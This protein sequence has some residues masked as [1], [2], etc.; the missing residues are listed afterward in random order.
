MVNATELA[1]NFTGRQVGHNQG[2][3]QDLNFS[4]L[5]YNE[6]GVLSAFSKTNQN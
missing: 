6:G 2:Y 3:L 4:L 1:N 5:N